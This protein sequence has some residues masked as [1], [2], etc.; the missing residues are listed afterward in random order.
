EDHLMRIF[1]SDAI[2]RVMG[3]F[4]IPE[5][6]PIQNSMITRSLEKAQ[7]RIEELNFDARK[8]VLSYDDVLNIQRQSVYARR[9]ALLTGTT[10]VVEEELERISLGNESLTAS[11]A[12]KKEQLGEAFYPSVR[13]VLLQ[14]VDF[15][16]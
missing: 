15:L 7:Q 3:S 6:E 16:W 13:R 5:D 8:H 4:G 10:E 11:I 1:A 14:T 9:R 2:K 12:Q